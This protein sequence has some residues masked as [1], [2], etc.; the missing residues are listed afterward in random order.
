MSVPL[1][2][3]LPRVLVALAATV[4]IAWFAVLARDE[5]IGG[6]AAERIHHRPDM[7]A[8]DWARSID[9]LRAAELLDPGTEWSVRRASYLVLRDKAAA[10]RVAESVVRREPD[11]LDAWV[12]LLRATRGRDPRRAQQALAQVSRLNPPLAGR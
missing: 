8:A 4:L 10:A 11:N 3:V 2:S 12:A 1:R 7:D 5:A 9:P 6:A